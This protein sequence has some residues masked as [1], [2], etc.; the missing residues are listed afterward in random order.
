MSLQWFPCYV[1]DL[2]GSMRWKC[3]TPAQ[4]G[5]YWQLICW[6]MQAEDGHLPAEAEQLCALSDLDLSD[7][8]SCVLDAFPIDSTGRRANVR[9]LR[10]WHKR[11]SVSDERRVAGAKGNDLR[12][13]KDRNCDQVGIANGSPLLQHPQPQSDPTATPTPRQRA[14]KPALLY[15]WD[16]FAALYPADKLVPDAKAK[17]WWRKHMT[18]D[19]L[20]NDLLA[21]T[22]TWVAS[23]QYQDGFGFG[24]CRFLTEGV[25]KTLP[26][27]T[28]AHGVSH[29][30]EVPPERRPAAYKI[31]ELPPEPDEPVDQGSLREALEEARRGLRLGGGA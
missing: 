12:W 19:L 15:R 9:A 17:A 14:S 25:W 6:Q 28:G 3:M 21:A 2:L 4:R 18:S 8:N 24:A 11:R 16:D 10:E 23:R 20:V 27:D 5:A 26:K 31:I 22:R 7:P 30:Q 13:Q 1:N 29:I